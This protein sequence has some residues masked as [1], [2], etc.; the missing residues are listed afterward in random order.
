ME[1]GGRERSSRPPGE[2]QGGILRRQRRRAVEHADGKGGAGRAERVDPQEVEVRRA[3]SGRVGSRRRAREL[4]EEVH[5][6]SA[7]T[8]S[9]RRRRGTRVDGARPPERLGGTELAMQGRAD[10]RRKGAGVG[11]ARAGV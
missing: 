10:R 3:C 6:A 11:G 9:W 2:G 8:P 7:A 4:A 1:R 5:G